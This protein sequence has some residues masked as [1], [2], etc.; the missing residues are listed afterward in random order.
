[1]DVM[2]RTRAKFTR[3]ALFKRMGPPMAPDI[4]MRNHT[5]QAAFYS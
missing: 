5:I 4:V 3:D 1:M 2:I